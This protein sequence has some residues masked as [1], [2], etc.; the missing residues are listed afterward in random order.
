MIKFISVFIL[1]VTD[2]VSG[3]SY[4]IPNETKTECETQGKVLTERTR[5][6]YTCVAG[7]TPV[8]VRK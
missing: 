1:V 6:D 8:Y 5:F 2:H 4:T 3:I 7:K